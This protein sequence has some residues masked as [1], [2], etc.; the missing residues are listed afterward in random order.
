M[1]LEANLIFEKLKSEFNDSIL[2]LKAEGNSDPFINVKPENLI[3]IC[4]FLRNDENLLFDYL[5]CLSGMDYKTGLGVVYNLYS[6]T[7]GHK[8]TLKVVVDKNNPVVP[9]I[10]KVW[11]SANWHEREAFDL[12]GVK[13]DGHPNLIRIL[14]PYDWDGHPLQKDYKTPE[15]YHGMKVPY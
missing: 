12:I 10:E 6:F 5:S 11:K 2:E 4:L 8:I 15:V 7:F 1:K 13:F 14:C 9:S 3:N